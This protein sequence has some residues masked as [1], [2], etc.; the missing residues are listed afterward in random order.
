TLV[1]EISPNLS[2][3]IEQISKSKN[4]SEYTI[5]FAM[6]S[7]LLSKMYNS[8]DF[9]LGTV[10]SG[11]NY[12]N[13]NSIGM[14]VNTLPI[15]V[16]PK[17]NLKLDDYIDKVNDILLSA[18]ENQDYQFDQL[19]SD[20]HENNQSNNPFFDCMFVYQNYNEQSYFG[21][22]ADKIT[23]KSTNAKFKLTFEIEVL[24]NK[25]VLYINYDSSYF[26]K[27]TVKNLEY[28][29]YKILD[30]FR[31]DSTL[32]INQIPLVDLQKH[33]KNPSNKFRSVV[34][35]IEKQVKMYPNKLAVRFNDVC[36]NYTELNSEVNRVANYLLNHFKVSKGDLVPLLLSRS[37]K[38]VIAILA[39]L[40]AGAAY[41]PISKK[42]PQERIDYILEACNSNIIIDD[43][44]MSQ[45]F[46]QN[47]NQNPNIEIN[48]NDLA[49]VIF[50][51]GTTGNPKGVMVEHGNLSNYCIEVIKAENSGMYPENINAAFFEYVF[52]ASLHDLVRPFVH[53]ESS[54]IFDTDLIYDIDKFILELNKHSISAI[55]MTPSLAGKLDL[56]NVPTMKTIFC[57]GE[58]ITQDVIEKYRD[59]KIQLKNCYGPTET[60]IM[61]FVN[62]DVRDTSI[63]KPI[64]GVYA[65][66]LDDDLQPLPKGAI[67]NL[68]IGGSQ[69]SR[70]Y[71]NQPEETQKH[72][73]P[74]PFDGGIMYETGDLLRERMDGSY[75]YLGR[76]DFQVK[77][78][79]FRIELGEIEKVIISENIVKQVAVVPYNDNL[80]AYYISD[81]QVSD[82]IFE[83]RLLSKLPSYMIPQFFV[84][85]DSLPITINGKLDKTLL[86]EPYLKDDYKEPV[87]QNEKEVAEAFCNV[88]KLDRV[89]VDASF[90]KLGGNSIVAIELANLI[91][92]PVKEIFEKKTV[93]N[94]A[95]SLGENLVFSLKKATNEE[96][97]IS[98][99]QEQLLY[100]DSLE[101]GTSAYNIPL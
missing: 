58:A 23:Y 59:T 35:E 95:N 61:S 97:I 53:G 27:N 77:I 92:V 99:E 5:Y 91:N 57:G 68:Y 13:Q 9:V 15:R 90:F 60:T 1:S 7:I 22:A 85:L 80:V 46:E 71:I 45:S 49:Y 33:K 30:N 56:T 55:G 83:E 75:E 25:K 100:I 36:W 10:S 87:T 29:F 32:S 2:D 76:K 52:D 70:G 21:G 84:K 93:R 74:N 8:S 69:V 31:L 82:E 24:Q 41:V 88:L 63:G 86:P 37:D 94:I 42:Y 72:F 14:F 39:V 3:K 6:F 11:R 43:E 67:G 50:T 81:K 4:V 17:G 18:I 98:F 54:V 47:L 73:I 40:K 64:G 44:F 96:N 65:Y 101:N 38:M 66:I 19:V 62:N 20:F 48:S 78:R 28:V 89:S 79:G 12:N 51:S 16:K 34:K 26:N